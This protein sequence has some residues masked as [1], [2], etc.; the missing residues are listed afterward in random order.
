MK[1]FN[2]LVTGVIFVGC[3]I[4]AGLTV[5][6]EAADWFNKLGQNIN[7]EVIKPTEKAFV[8]AG[9]AIDQEVIQ[10]VGKAFSQAGR[11]IDTH[12][13]QPIDFNVIKPIVGIGDTV[14]NIV[15]MALLI[16]SMVGPIKQTVA[17]ITTQIDTLSGIRSG[18]DIVDPVFDILQELTTLPPHFQALLDKIAGSMSSI[19]DIV[20]PSS[21][22]DADKIKQAAVAMQSISASVDQMTRKIGQLNQMLHVRVKNMAESA[23][24]ATNEIIETI[25]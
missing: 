9:Q 15:A 1:S 17:H 7:N 19:E 20:R 21:A 5:K 25:K 10:P 8:Q 2:R 6:V 4:L 16:K 24:Q 18:K 14:G 3:L 13:I 12:V 22:R 23:E 11:E